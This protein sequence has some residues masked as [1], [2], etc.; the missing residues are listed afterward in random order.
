MTIYKC[1][2]CRLVFALPDRAAKIEG[3]CNDGTAVVLRRVK[4]P[5][6]RKSKAPRK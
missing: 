3:T 1:P 2:R 5:A 4:R 6:S